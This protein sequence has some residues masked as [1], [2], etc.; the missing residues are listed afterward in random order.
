M[1]MS[2]SVLK[3]MNVSGQLWGE[4]VRHSMHLLNRLPRKTMGSRTHFEAWC[5][6]KPQLGHLRVF[7]YTAHVRSSLPHL[8]KLDD[9]SKPMVYLWVEEGSKAHRLFDPHTKRIVVSR[10]VLFEE[11]K[12]WEW[13]SEFSE[14][15][16]FVVEE[17]VGPNI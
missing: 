8:K 15:L 1:E 12:A 3:S 7:G 17:I 10:D 4:A 5:G 14:G 9:R 13:T 16:D 6:R 2:R 11:T